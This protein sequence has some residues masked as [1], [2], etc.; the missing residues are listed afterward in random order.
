MH[1]GKLG[2]ALSA[3]RCSYC[4][5]RVGRGEVPARPPDPARTRQKPRADQIAGRIALEASRNDRHRPRRPKAHAAARSLVRPL[6]ETGNGRGAKGPLCQNGGGGMSG[7]SEP[8]ADRHTRR[9]GADAHKAASKPPDPAC[10][11]CAIPL[12]RSMGRLGL[13]KKKGAVRRGSS[14]CFA[15]R[16]RKS[17]QSTSGA[18]HPAAPSVPC[19]QRK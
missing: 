16:F 19:P 13:R 3:P 8:A 9:A 10:C 2:A 14:E 1:G 15:A 18:R 12:P 7:S 5:D 4:G 17:P 6:L 11:P